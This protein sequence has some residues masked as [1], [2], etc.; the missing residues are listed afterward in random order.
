MVSY[1]ALANLLHKYLRNAP[2][3]ARISVEMSEHELDIIHIFRLGHFDGSDMLLMRLTNMK[4]ILFMS[5]CPHRF[6]ANHRFH[7]ESTDLY[8]LD[9][10]AFVKR[11]FHY[12]DPIQQKHTSARR[13]PYTH[14]SEWQTQSHLRI[15]WRDHFRGISMCE[16]QPVVCISYL[17]SFAWWPW[18]T[19][20]STA[21]KKRNKITSKT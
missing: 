12:L 7:V 4:N 2:P 9:V 15:Q 19:R 16:Y 5:Q 10:C 1:T 18:T 21:H 3:V 17:F 11:R 14:I 20:R 8:L 6:T 13:T